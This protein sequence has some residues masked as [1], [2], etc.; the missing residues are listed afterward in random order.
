MYSASKKLYWTWWILRISYGLLFILVGT[1]KFFNALTQWQ[2]FIGTATGYMPMP[3]VF[4][5]K[6]LAL[7]QIIAGILLFTPWL[8][9]GIYLMFGLLGI[10][11]LS[12]ITAS[13]GIVVIAH[14]IF[15]II[16]VYVLLQ[17]TGI[18]K[19]R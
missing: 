11:F 2:Q 18:L 9:A 6:V 13:S 5:L 12:L 15:M 10:I 3:P 19:A 14:D 17:L 1:D 16:N 8:L 7:L 4:I